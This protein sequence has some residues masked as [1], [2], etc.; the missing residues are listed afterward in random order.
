MFGFGDGNMMELFLFIP[1]ISQYNYWCV[2]YSW[3]FSK[4]L[5]IDYP[6]VYAG[7]KCC[8]EVNI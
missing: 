8:V 4:K 1:I 3:K 6:D 2:L 7:V 5:D